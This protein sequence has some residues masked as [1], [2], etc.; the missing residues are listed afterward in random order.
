[1]STVEQQ[2]ANQIATIEKATGRS[3]TEGD[4]TGF[5][6]TVSFDTA[7]E[8]DM[9]LKYGAEHGMNQTYGRLDDLLAV[10]TGR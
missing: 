9:L 3:F 4:Q 6:I 5:T 7:E 2:P 1:M 8:R 10:G